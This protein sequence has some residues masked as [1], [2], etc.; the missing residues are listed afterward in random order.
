MK[1]K[2]PQR[3]QIVPIKIRLIKQIKT[4]LSRLKHKHFN[5]AVTFKLS[6]TR[7]I[8]NKIN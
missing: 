4:T 6:C 7:K 8:K 3:K 2:K 1:K 5:D